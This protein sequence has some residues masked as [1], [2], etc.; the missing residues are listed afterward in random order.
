MIYTASVITDKNTTKKNPKE[1]SL[2]IT[3][4]IISKVSILFPK[5]CVGLVFCQLFIG[6]HQFV[7]STEGQF[8]RGNDILIESPE[9]LEIN[10]A[11]RTITIKTWNLDDT[12]DHSVEVM[13]T[14]LPH[15]A[16]PELGFFE[17][18]V[19]SLKT[20]FLREGRTA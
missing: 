17:G 7:P 11:P 9:F 8:L 3:E 1:T 12:Y 6:G 14:Q 5:G 18:V 16:F 13:I 2:K 10:T 20:L 15:R 4:G 19:K